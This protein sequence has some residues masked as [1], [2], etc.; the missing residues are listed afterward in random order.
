MLIVCFSRPALRI[1][2]CGTALAAALTVTA[3]T[4][5]ASKPLEWEPWSRSGVAVALADHLPALVIVGDSS[6]VNAM[7][8][9]S[10]LEMLPCKLVL[11]LSGARLFRSDGVPFTEYLHDTGSRLEP[12]TVLLLHPSRVA[13]APQILHVQPSALQLSKALTPYI[14]SRSRRLAM[15][16]LCCLALLALVAVLTAREATVLMV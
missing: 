11:Y 16:M 13:E 1:L 9:T 3:L 14:A 5:R 10:T 8:S 6:S 12:A 4:Y 7:R 2:M 15:C